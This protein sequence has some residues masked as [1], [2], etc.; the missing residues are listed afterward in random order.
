MKA[1]RGSESICRKIWTNDSARW[2]HCGKL[3]TILNTC[4]ACWTWTRLGW[5]CHSNAHSDGEYSLKLAQWY[6]CDTKS[7]Q[8][9]TWRSDAKFRLAVCYIGLRNWQLCLQRQKLCWTP[10]LSPVYIM[11]HQ[12]P[13]HL[14]VLFPGWQKT[15]LSTTKDY[16]STISGNLT[17]AGGCGTG[18]NF[19]PALGTDGEKDY[20]M[21]LKSE[22][23]KV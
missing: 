14:H 5:S 18:R 2:R 19:W 22:I 9:E 11:M 7:T 12:N 21:D 4:G 1:T 20:L 15:Y 10:A 8:C 17:W 6:K 16:V 23:S 13:S 3:F